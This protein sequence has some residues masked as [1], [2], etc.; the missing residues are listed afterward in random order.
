MGTSQSPLE[1]AGKMFRAGQAAG[2]AAQVGTAA[3]AALVKRTILAGS[4]SRLRNVGK[5]G[6]NLG[7][8]YTVDT[9]PDGAKALIF[10][11]GPWQ[12]IERDTRPHQIPRQRVSD[13]FVGVFGHAVIPG[14]SEAFP[15]GKRGVRT[16]VNH[17]GTRGKRPFE[18]GVV[19]AQPLVPKVYAAAVEAHLRTIF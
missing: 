19:A 11:T 18:K 3:G 15:H 10:A 8:R 5:T 2:N 12:I 6:R 16:K 4:P 7:V 13:S 1:Y 9:Y 17:P 14:G